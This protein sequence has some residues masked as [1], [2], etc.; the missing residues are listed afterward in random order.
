M[1][2]EERNNAIAV[3]DRLAD[4]LDEM[5]RVARATRAGENNGD[6]SSVNDVV[7]K[8][9]NRKAA[10]ALSELLEDAIEIARDAPTVNDGGSGEGK[11]HATFVERL[12]QRHYPVMAEK[13]EVR[14]RVDEE[15]DTLRVRLL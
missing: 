12:E 3:A 4:C 1:A 6:V 13:L 7:R 15:D 5:A 10:D 2:T 9:I 8:R 11:L 14:I